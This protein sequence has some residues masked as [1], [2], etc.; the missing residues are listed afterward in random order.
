MEG[1]KTL[2]VRH[3]G[4]RRRS[5]IGTSAQLI[6]EPPSR[7]RHQWARLLAWVLRE[8]AEP[9]TCRP[10]KCWSAKRKSEEVTVAMIGR[11]TEPVLAKGLC[12]VCDQAKAKALRAE[13]PCRSL[14]PSCQHLWQGGQSR[15]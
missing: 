11:T 9:I 7:P 3:R 15:R 10:W 8:V 1:A 2:E 14:G 4:T 6:V 13:E 12:Q 5:G